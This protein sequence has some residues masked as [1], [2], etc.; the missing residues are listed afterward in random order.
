MLILAMLKKILII[1]LLLPISS[2]MGIEQIKYVIAYNEASATLI[3]LIKAAYNEIGLRPEFILVPSERAI[4][5]TNSG[6]YDAD[7]ARVEGS[8]EKYPNLVFTKEP[9][10]KTE[11]F[12]YALKGAKFTISNTDDIKKHSVG[13]VRGSKLPEIFVETENIKVEK[14]NSIQIFYSMFELKRF[15]IALVTNTQLLTDLG[16]MNKIA[17]RVGPV[18]KSS[19]SFHVLNKRHQDLIPKLDSA[20][21]KI[22]STRRFGVGGKKTG[23]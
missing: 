12:A 15:E 18:L 8:L 1:L 11:L 22:K 7:L 3:P 14:A 19:R 10:K 5:G 21:R 2:S 20:L 13:L 17:T 23:S 4:F 16:H 6:A 9:L